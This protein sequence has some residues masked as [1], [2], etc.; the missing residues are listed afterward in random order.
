MSS[1]LAILVFSPPP[2]YYT[3]LYYIVI[4]PPCIYLT[5][6]SSAPIKSWFVPST[7]LAITHSDHVV[8]PATLT[9]F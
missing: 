7:S 4:V 9:S 1:S 8:I 6:S 2:S 3:I 5:S